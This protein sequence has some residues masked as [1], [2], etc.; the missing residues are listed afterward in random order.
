MTFPLAT[1]F[2]ISRARRALAPVLALL[3]AAL[4]HAAA[5]DAGSPGAQVQ[6]PLSV[7]DQMVEQA[8]DPK[9]A[10]RPAPALYALGAASLVVDVNE[11]DGKV[12]AHATLQL[13]VR[14]FEGGKAAAPHLGFAG[15]E[16]LV[17]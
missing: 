9:Q 7:Y 3:A 10:E 17:R 14:V 2:T 15:K 13:P 6:L 5:A 11:S 8:R 16:Q 12:F 4:P 1:S